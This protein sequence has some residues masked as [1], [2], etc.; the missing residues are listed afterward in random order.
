[1]SYYHHLFETCGDC[2][3]SVAFTDPADW[4]RATAEPAREFASLTSAVEYLLGKDVD[5]QRAVVTAH[6][7]LGNIDI[8]PDELAE[9]TAL[10]ATMRRCQD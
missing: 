4:K 8:S 9:L 10:T 3:V 5:L 2:R 6:G 1:M 7:A